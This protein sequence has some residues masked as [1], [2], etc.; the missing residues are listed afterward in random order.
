[1]M[2][3]S[4]ERSSASAKNIDKIRIKISIAERVYPF[5]IKREEEEGIRKA[6]KLIKEKVMYYRQ[7]Y[8]DRDAQDALS[9][10]TL[11]FVL[12]LIDVTEN[13]NLQAIQDELG[14]LNIEFENYLKLHE[15][16]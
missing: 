16:K 10:A 8:V 1:M 11:Q 14:D 2:N 7:K 13:A 3:E 6:A 4:N 9:M 12:K 15:K 5:R